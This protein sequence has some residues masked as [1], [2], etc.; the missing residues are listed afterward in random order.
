[1]EHKKIMKQEDLVRKCTKEINVI[2]GPKLTNPLTQKEIRSVVGV[3]FAVIEE[4]LTD[5][6]MVVIRTPI[7][8]FKK[9]YRGPYRH[10]NPGSSTWGEVEGSTKCKFHLG[11]ATKVNLSK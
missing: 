10:F 6:D 1:M 4:A 8:M 5:P 2:L 3:P 9:Y 11:K 7:G